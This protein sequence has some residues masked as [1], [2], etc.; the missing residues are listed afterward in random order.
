M[1]FAEFLVSLICNVLLG[2][3][4]LNIMYGKAFLALLP[5]RAFKNLVMWPVNSMLFYTI[6]KTVEATGILRIIRGVKLMPGNNQ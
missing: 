1:L 3:L 6:A 4:W 5:M 2:T